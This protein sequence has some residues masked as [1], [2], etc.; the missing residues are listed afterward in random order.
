MTDRVLVTGAAGFAG[1]HVVEQ[2]AG[3]CDVVAWARERLPAFKYPRRAVVLDRLPLGPTGKVLRR[4][5]SEAVEPTVVAPRRPWSR[6]D[7]LRL[8]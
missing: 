1:S 2:L 5:L 7:D 4:A 6:L 3:S 8:S